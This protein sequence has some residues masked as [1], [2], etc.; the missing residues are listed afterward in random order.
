MPD[1][2]SLIKWKFKTEHTQPALDLLD[3]DGSLSNFISAESI[4]LA[5]GPSVKPINIDSLIPI[6]LCDSISV[7]NNKNIIQLFEIGSKLPYLLPGR[8]VLQMQLNRVVFNGDSLLGALTRGH[9]TVEEGSSADFPGVNTTADDRQ[10]RF[11]LNLA[12]SFFN[13]SFGLGIFIQD[14]D[15]QAGQE[16]R[17]QW[18]A[19]FYAENC[20]IQSHQMNIQGQQYIVM[21]SALVRCTNLIPFDG[22]QS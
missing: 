8:S 14:S 3:D 13:K 12:A 17:G 19:A 1:P 15:K 22:L 11:Y 4:V 9:T 6:G 2:N 18:V 7:Q 10:G 20:M 5:A 16:G 21:E